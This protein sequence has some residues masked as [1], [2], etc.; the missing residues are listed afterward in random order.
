MYTVAYLGFGKGGPWRARRARAYNGGLEAE[1]PAGSRGRVPG[2]KGQGAKPPEAE[3]LFSSE[4]LM[5]TAN[6]PIF[7]KF[8]NAKDH[9]TL[10]NFAILAEKWQKRTFPYKVAC[11]KFSWS[12]QRGG[13]I[14]PSP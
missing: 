11:K 3:T 1:P 13:A 8:G 2:R 7:L 6:L 5:E 9:Q 12:A 14:A 4:C 10:L